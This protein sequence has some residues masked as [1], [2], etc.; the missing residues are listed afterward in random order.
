MS[1]VSYMFAGRKWTTVMLLVIAA[2]T[3]AGF[4]L[5]NDSI[6]HLHMPIGGGLVGIYLPVLIAFANRPSGDVVDGWTPADLNVLTI[7]GC[8]IAVVY[9]VIAAVVR[10]N[11]DFT[12]SATVG[13]VSGAIATFGVVLMAFVKK[14]AD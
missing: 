2:T 13:L 4:A 6:S 12:D 14:Y 3:A 8:T 10:T 11:V 5:S 9:F 7:S 1:T